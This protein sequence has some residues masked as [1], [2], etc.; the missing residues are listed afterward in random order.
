MKDYWNETLFTAEDD[1]R[2]FCYRYNS[3][4]QQISLQLSK[5]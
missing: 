1:I 5:N 3:P 2:G 4:G